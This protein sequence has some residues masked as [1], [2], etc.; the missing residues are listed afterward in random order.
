[1]GAS[2]YWGDV[3]ARR[4]MQELKEARHSNRDG[5]AV[6]EL[7]AQDMTALAIEKYRCSR[8][9]NSTGLNS[10]GVTRG[11]F[12]RPPYLTRNADHDSTSSHSSPKNTALHTT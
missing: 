12:A 10:R 6:N 2:L 8:I 1:M 4:E 7:R 11:K 3:R 9:W 5:L